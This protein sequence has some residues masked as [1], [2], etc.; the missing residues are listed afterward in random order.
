MRILAI[1]G[2]PRKKNNTAAMLEAVVKGA[3]EAGADGQVL[4][5]YDYQYKG[6]VS[7]FACKRKGAA[8]DGI[9]AV[10]DELQPVLEKSMV[11]DILVLGS[12]IYFGNVS[13]MMRSYMERLFFMNFSYDTYGMN[14]LTRRINTA[15]IYTMNA[16]LAQ[17]DMYAPMFEQ[18]K[19]LLELFGG[20]SK[21]CMAMDTWQFEDYGKYNASRF[22]V[23]NKKRTREEQFPLDLQRAKEMGKRLVTA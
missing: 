4:H 14:N 23:E 17:V 7:C 1:N 11:A 9:C 12:P 18:N 6:C 16:T 3:A 21:Y 2:S 19:R 5:L 10:K 20:V 22:D 13:G 15:F 8:Y